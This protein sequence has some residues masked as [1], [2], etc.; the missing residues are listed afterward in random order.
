MKT[1]EYKTAKDWLKSLPKHTDR[2]RAFYYDKREND[3]PRYRDSMG[4]S[5]S[6]DFETI[7][8]MVRCEI[9]GLKVWEHECESF[10]DD[11]DQIITV[12][13]MG[14][15]M[16]KPVTAM[17]PN[18]RQSMMLKEHCIQIEPRVWASKGCIGTYVLKCPMSGRF[19]FAHDMRDFGGQLVSVKWINEKKNEL[20]IKQHDWRPDEYEI[21]KSFEYCG[22]ELEVEPTDGPGWEY[23]YVQA[24]QILKDRIPH[25]SY[26]KYDGSLQNGFEIVTNP[27]TWD[28]IRGEFADVIEPLRSLGMRSHESGRCGLHVHLPR[29]SMSKIELAKLVVLWNSDHAWIKLISGRS[30]TTAQSST[31]NQNY[32]RLGARKLMFNGGP[33]CVDHYSAI[34]TSN[35]HTVEFRSY[36]GTLNKD[37]LLGRIGICFLVR[38]Y[39]KQSNINPSWEGF[40][41]WLMSKPYER[42]RFPESWALLSACCNKHEVFDKSLREEVASMKSKKSNPNPSRSPSKK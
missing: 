4:S 14:M 40:F 23:S 8:T 41:S 7:P 16:C 3:Y 38:S 1:E 17:T 9:T 11:R 19:V 10:R 37:T 27:I 22:V 21:P 15:S 35:P 31:R 2:T 33:A 34:N 13:R 28:S 24:A 25:L 18:G 36:R 39:I 42:K 32:C 12:S 30:G 29:N 26:Q 6:V 5:S 20:V